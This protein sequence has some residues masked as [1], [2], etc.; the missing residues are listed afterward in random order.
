MYYTDVVVTR[1]P[2]YFTGTS[3]YATKEELVQTSHT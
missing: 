2:S 3:S 1:K